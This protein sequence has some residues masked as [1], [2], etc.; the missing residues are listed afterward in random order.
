MKRWPGALV[1]LLLVL[2]PTVGVVWGAAADPPDLA[3][4]PRHRVLVAIPQHPGALINVTAADM[5]ASPDVLALGR[6]STLALEQCAANNAD[7]SLRGGLRG[8]AR[9]A[10]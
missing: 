2:L 8:A 3:R 5:P 9:R 1:L 7:P 10:R 6:R 4:D